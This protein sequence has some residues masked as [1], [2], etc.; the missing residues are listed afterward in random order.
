M[1]YVASTGGEVKGTL[2]DARKII[3]LVGLGYYVA[4]RSRA[5]SGFYIHNAVCMGF[6]PLAQGVTYTLPKLLNRAIYF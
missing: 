2:D 3:A 6:T 5:M 4:A 1:R